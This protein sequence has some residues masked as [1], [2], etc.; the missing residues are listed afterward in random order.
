[1]TLHAVTFGDLKTSDAVAVFLHGYGS[2]ERD[3]VGLRGALPEGLPW[4]S[5]RAPLDLAPGSYSWFEIV[6]RGNPSLETLAPAIAALWAWIDETLAPGARVVPIGFSQGGLMASE[7]LRSD[8]ARVLA[9]VLLGGFVAAGIRPEDERLAAERPAVFSGRGAE[10]TVLLPATKERTDAWL[11]AHSTLTA[12][13]YP[14]LG[15]GINAAEL[16]DVRAF[17]AE[18]LAE[19]TA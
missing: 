4:A 19:V 6:E 13:V 16:A 7:L 15:H 17:L 11:P 2:N 14:G 3:L 12:P 9:P 8:A 18:Q 10:D 5:L 1:M